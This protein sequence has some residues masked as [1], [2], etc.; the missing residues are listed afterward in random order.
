MTARHSSLAAG[1][2]EKLSLAEQLGN[3]GSEVGRAISG[4]DD[5]SKRAAAERAL[6]LFDLTLADRRW[7]GR[8]S[9]LARAREVIRDFLCGRNEYRSD[10]AGL[11]RYFMEFA[12]AARLSR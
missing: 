10:P 3:I 5:D 4:A 1:Q 8:G 11:E 7:Y 12:L 2:W 6:E 9:E